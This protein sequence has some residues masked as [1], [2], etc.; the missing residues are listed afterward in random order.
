MKQEIVRT[1]KE[2]ARDVSIYNVRQKKCWALAVEQLQPYLSKHV[3]WETVPREEMTQIIP[4]D[5]NYMY[6]CELNIQEIAKDHPQSTLE[7][8]L[9][10]C[11]IKISGINSEGNHYTIFFISGL[12]KDDKTGKVY[13]LITLQGIRWLLNFGQKQM[14][15]AFHKPSFLR[16]SSSYSMDLFLL[17]SENYKRCVFDISVEE[18]KKRL[19]CPKDY[20]SKSIRH[21][22]LESSLQEFE[23][24]QSDISFQYVFF[25]TESRKMK[26]RRTLNMIKFAV[27][28][29]NEDG[30]YSPTDE[31]TWTKAH[32]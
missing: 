26:G 25:S 1:S 6:R 30:S 24:K 11:S 7:N 18:F 22:V 31:E 19:R 15:V 13:G 3:D 16:L 5:R 2:S 14:F 9:D 17:L 23:R 29:R 8:I 10:M 20:N 12:E 27:L 4:L 32:K 28:H 21:R